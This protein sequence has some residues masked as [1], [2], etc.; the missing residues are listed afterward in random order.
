MTSGDLHIDLSEKMT[1]VT[2]L[3]WN[4]HKVS[5]AAYRISLSF[6]V[7]EIEG[8]LKSTPPRYGEACQEARH[9]AG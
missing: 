3:G 4:P 7:S 2:Y 8:G 6:L 9:G 1:E 5:N